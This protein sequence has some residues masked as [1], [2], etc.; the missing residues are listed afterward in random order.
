MDTITA[1]KQALVA[2]EAALSDDKPYI[3][4]S[5]DAITALRVAIEVQEKHN[6]RSNKLEAENAE[7]SER[8]YRISIGL[9]QFAT[10]YC[11]QCGGEFGPANNGYSHCKEHFK[12]TPTDVIA[13]IARQL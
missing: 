2:L 7:L 4:P 13:D 12:K 9:P 5:Q 8:L 1:M 3:I 11:S 10:V 6:F